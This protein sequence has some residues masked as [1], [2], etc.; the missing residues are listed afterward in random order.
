M[1]QM[2]CKSCGSPAVYR[3]AWAEWD[4]DE[5]TW[6]LGNVFDYAHCTRCDGETRI[7]EVP[8]KE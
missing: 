1:K 2:Q 3:D 4:V 6:I 5:Q 7:E 8:L